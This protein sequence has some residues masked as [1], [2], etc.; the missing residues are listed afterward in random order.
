MVI[1]DLDDS[2]KRFR[3]AP[4]HTESAEGRKADPHA[5][6]AGPAS[7]AVELERIEKNLP[8]VHDGFLQT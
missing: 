3:S 8:V 1:S 5:C 2:V 7:V 4:F 6:G